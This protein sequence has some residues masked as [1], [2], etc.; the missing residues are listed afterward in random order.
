MI[1]APK[2]ASLP[3]FPKTLEIMLQ[4]GN[5]QG[6]TK[7]I[8]V[9]GGSTLNNLQTLQMILA[10][11]GGARTLEVG[12]AC[13]LSA[14]VF[15]DHHR[16]QNAGMHTAIDPFQDDLDGCGLV[17][18]EVEGL[19]GFLRFLPELSHEALP[20]LLRDG[21]RF[22][23]IYIDGSHLFEHVFLDLYFA[24][25]L[26]NN[27]GVVLMDDSTWPDVAKTIA[28]ARANLAGSLEELDLAPFRADGGTSMRYRLGRALGRKQMTGFRRI[29]P[30]ERPWDAKL[31]RF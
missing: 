26:L 10:M 20:R 7:S 25:R 18:I 8:P 6:R 22:D 19:S 17:Q 30:I 1:V 15:C 4:T 21:E 2:S 9:M 16:R 28:F 31:N 23:C 29:G 13:G 11:E 24:A 5:A 27:N 3:T 14:L 12:L